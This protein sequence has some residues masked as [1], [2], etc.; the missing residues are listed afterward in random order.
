MWTD[1]EL[2]QY[3]Y[4]PEDDPMLGHLSVILY[5]VA[6]AASVVLTIYLVLRSPMHSPL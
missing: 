3:A 4:D 5:L 6:A 1:Q 2:D